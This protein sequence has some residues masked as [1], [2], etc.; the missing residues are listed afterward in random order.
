[1][2]LV[3]MRSIPEFEPAEEHG[4]CHSIF[5]LAFIWPDMNA[6]PS[7]RSIRDAVTVPCLIG[8]R[9]REFHQLPTTPFSYL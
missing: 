7:L 6:A 5:R 3:F 9:D 4:P 2:S 8:W 1:M